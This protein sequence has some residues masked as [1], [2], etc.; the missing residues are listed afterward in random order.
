[1][2]KQN[3]DTHSDLLFTLIFFGQKFLKGMIGLDLLH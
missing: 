2:L 3:K 1:M